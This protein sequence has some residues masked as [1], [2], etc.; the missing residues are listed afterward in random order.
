MKVAGRSVLADYVKSMS[1][2]PSFEQLISLLR[3]AAEWAPFNR[4]L[5]TEA[6]QHA[7]RC[8]DALLQTNKDHPHLLLLRGLIQH[9][10]EK[11]DQAREAW[12]I[13][14]SSYDRRSRHHL[15]REFDELGLMTQTEE[16]ALREVARGE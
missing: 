5:S 6:N 11:I 10:L 9:R 7:L 14:L 1:D 13:A 2:P 4:P 8:T 15:A 12:K 16:G 3:K